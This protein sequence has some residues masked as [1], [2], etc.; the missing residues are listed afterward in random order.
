MDNYIYWGLAIIAPSLLVIPFR[1]FSQNNKWSHFFASLGMIPI[2][3]Y[4]VYYKSLLLFILGIVAAVLILLV[5]ELNLEKR[6]VIKPRDT[7]NQKE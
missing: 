5:I 6:G 1:F 2:A 7:T 3:A 4:Y